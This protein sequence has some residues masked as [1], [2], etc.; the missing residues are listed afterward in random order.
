V[1]ELRLSVLSW[2]VHGLP[3]PFSK[4]RKARLARVAAAVAT[5][6]PDIAVFQ[7]AWID[8]ARRLARALPGY[9]P[10]FVAWRGD[11]VRSGL[12]M[13]V[14]RDGQWNVDASGI[15][16]REFT[17][18]GPLWKVWQADGLARKGALFVPLRQGA[19]RLWM[20]DVHLQARYPGEPYTEL[21]L[22]QLRELQQW[23]E[24]LG[25]AIPVVTAGDFNTPADEEEV[26][27][28]IARL[29]A[30]CCIPS[31]QGER[32]VTNYPVHSSAAWIDYVLAR[33]AA[34]GSASGSTRLLRNR[35]VDDPYSDHHGLVV[36]VIV[37]AA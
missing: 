1:R 4:D 16:F 19:T 11:W 5:E 23:I 26:Y 8:G 32:D 12:M 37:D 21:R 31:H 6:R 29:G 17:A 14:R 13:A 20:V 3:E 34:G 2:N 25:R 36:Q 33:P 10:C 15:H 22:L 28:E 35:G 30:D 24:D 9:E 27:R 18:R 7:E